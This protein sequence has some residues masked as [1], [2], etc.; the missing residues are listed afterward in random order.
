MFIPNPNPPQQTPKTLIFDRRFLEH[1]Y[2]L[3]DRSETNFFDLRIIDI[4]PNLINNAPKILPELPRPLFHI[5][6]L[7]IRALDVLIIT[8]RVQK[9]INQF[10]LPDNDIPHFHQLAPIHFWG[11][12]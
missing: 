11:L 1:I 3:I 8:I 4:P 12:C 2:L 6:K 5:I 10:F 9:L 7:S